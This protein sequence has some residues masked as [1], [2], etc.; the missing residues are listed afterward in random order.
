MFDENQKFVHGYWQ[1]GEEWPGFM[2]N[3]G[4][5]A[6]TP[7]WYLGDLQMAAEGD[8]VSP[9][10][11][12][13]VQ[14]PSKGVKPKRSPVVPLAVSGGLLLG[15]GLTYGLAGATRSQLYNQEDEAGILSVRNRTNTLVYISGGLLAGAVG[16]GVLGGLSVSDQG[17]T[18]HGK[19]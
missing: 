16:F 3:D 1:E 14:E 18:I 17:V 8:L 13:E 15:S 7:K 19:F 2:L 9:P 4:K 12:L 10:P 6:K 11:L 5:K